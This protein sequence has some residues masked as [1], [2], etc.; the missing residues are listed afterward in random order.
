M[1]ELLKSSG[2]HSMQLYKNIENIH[3][4]W[5]NIYMKGISSDFLNNRFLQQLRMY[6]IE[7]S[8]DTFLYSFKLAV[9]RFYEH[10]KQ[11]DG[12]FTLINHDMIKEED[13]DE[14]WMPLENLVKY[15]KSL[16]SEC[17]TKSGLFFFFLAID[18]EP[19]LID[20]LKGILCLPTQFSI[21]TEYSE[22]DYVVFDDMSYTG[23]QVKNTMQSVSSDKKHIVSAYI[24]SGAKEIF[25]QENI[26]VFTNEIIK[27]F[28]EN[29][30]S[31]YMLDDNYK[32]ESYPIVFSHK[33]A[34]N[35]SSFPEVYEKLARKIIPPYKKTGD[36]SY[37]TY[38]V[39][40]VV[41]N[42]LVFI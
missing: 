5:S 26:N 37:Y 36:H 6:T 28:G 31:R 23:M 2:K 1:A 9:D 15:D 42:L 22:Y 16:V 4:D 3:I 38:L 25:E 10:V 33:I 30:V 35:I 18:L 19:R 32:Y 11:T 24:G 7:V 8:V 21:P 13:Y 20:K 39:N 14:S 40:D 12:F 34:D 29:D 41:K 17:T 27:K